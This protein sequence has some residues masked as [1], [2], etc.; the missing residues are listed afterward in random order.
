[1]LTELALPVYDELC[2]VEHVVSVVRGQVIGVLV[3]PAARRRRR[4][5]NGNAQGI[6]GAVGQTVGQR[7]ELC[8]LDPANRVLI[9]VTRPLDATCTRIMSASCPHQFQHQRRV[10]SSCT[11]RRCHWFHSLKLRI[12]ENRI[13]TL[14]ETVSFLFI[15]HSLKFAIE[16]RNKIIIIVQC[17]EHG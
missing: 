8:N 1:L 4:V 10:Q 7:L 2:D 13:N 16:V 6:A 9:D 15:V 12:F 3:Y 5:I 14:L 17:S 11:R